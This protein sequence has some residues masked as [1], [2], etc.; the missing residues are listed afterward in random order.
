MTKLLEEFD[1]KITAERTWN[2]T[3]LPWIRGNFTHF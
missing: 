1:I 3:Y 2:F